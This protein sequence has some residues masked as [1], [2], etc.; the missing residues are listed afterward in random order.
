MKWCF[1]FLKRLVSLPHTML[2]R[3]WQAV[4][5]LCLLLWM[6]MQPALADLPTMEP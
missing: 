1:R 3:L 6:S 4:F 2:L 5:S